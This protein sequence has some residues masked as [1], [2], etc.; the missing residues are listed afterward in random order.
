MRLIRPA[1]GAEFSHRRHQVGF[2]H[3]NSR[4]A[5]ATP[6]TCAL[7]SHLLHAM[8]IAHSRGVRCRT[9]RHTNIRVIRYD[10]SIPCHG[11]GASRCCRQRL[12]ISPL[13]QPDSNSSGV[14]VRFMG[15][16]TGAQ[17]SPS[18]EPVPHGSTALRQRLGTARLHRAE[19]LA[20]V[21]T[22]APGRR[23][24]T[25]PR[26]K[27]SST[28]RTPETLSHREYDI[29]D[30]QHAPSLDTRTTSLCWPFGVAVATSAQRSA[31]TSTRCH[32]SQPSPADKVSS[33]CLATSIPAPPR[34]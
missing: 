4:L 15:A 3:D 10:R 20:A 13:Q 21:K 11:D 31:I 14:V 7:T 25:G 32:T 6:Y 2:Q 27:A 1:I 18:D 9:V 5:T 29:V 19:R 24:T 30:R 17:D 33:S 8:L 12:K 16:G 26:G 28:W 34:T 23:P 22:G